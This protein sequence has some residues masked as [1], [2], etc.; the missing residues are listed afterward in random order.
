MQC[1]GNLRLRV[2]ESVVDIVDDTMTMNRMKMQGKRRI[3]G[4]IMDMDDI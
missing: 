1:F 2:M 4:E 3:I